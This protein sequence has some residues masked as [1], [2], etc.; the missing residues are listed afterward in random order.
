MASSSRRIRSWV[1]TK[2]EGILMILLVIVLVPQFYSVFKFKHKRHHG[3]RNSPGTFLENFKIPNFKPKVIIKNR[4][5]RSNPLHEKLEQLKIELPASGG[6][7]EKVETTKTTTLTTVEPLALDPIKLGQSDQPVI[8]P[9]FDVPEHVNEP[10][11]DRGHLD[12][13]DLG[14]NPR[15]KLALSFFETFEWSL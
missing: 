3:N 11:R 13:S 12:T 7:V 2:W 6:Q 10:E 9:V 14:L 4:K 1:R 8:S 5:V 15:E